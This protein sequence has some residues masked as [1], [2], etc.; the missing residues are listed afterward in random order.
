MGGKV[1]ILT[2]GGDAPGMNAAIRAAALVALKSGWEVVGVE[3][4][5]RGLISGSFRPL[6]AQDVLPIIRFGGTVLGTARCLEFHHRE[7]RDT[8]R[9]RLLEAGINGLVVIG[10][11][12]SL[13]G[14][15]LLGDPAELGDQALT[16]VGVPASIDNDVGLAGMSIGVDTAM[17]TIVDACDKIDDTATAHGRTFI[18]EVMGRDCGYLAM[19]TSIAAGADVVLFRES[20]K[21][22]EDLIDEVADAVLAAHQ[23]RE[24]SRR[25][26]VIMAEGVRI[27]AALLKERVD[28]RLVAAQ[29]G[30]AETRVTIIGHVAR[31]GSPSAFDR[32]LASRL[33]FTAASGVMDGFGQRM[34]A[35]NP[36]R[37]VLPKDA[38][39]S[40][41]DPRCVLVRLEDVIA[42]TLAQ[43]EGNSPVAL[44]RA[45]AFDHIE[46]VLR[47]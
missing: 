29:H 44:W 19:V 1:G 9:A 32:V 45:R 39:R 41:I 3:Q 18:V 11:N 33:G 43:Q 42:E 30:E 24:R 16:I 28:A 8:A 47:V 22:P 17:N 13:T 15:Q 23:H 20:G 38:I 31:G 14:A 40:P 34:A 10:G 36:P 7:G 12:G 35:F 21:A 37:S 5:F 6:C 2:S 26:L 27:S 4:G 25:I 46:S